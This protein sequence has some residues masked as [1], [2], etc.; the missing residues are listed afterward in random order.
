MQIPTTSISL[1]VFSGLIGILG[2]YLGILKNDCVLF[3]H[4]DR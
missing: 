2:I 3:L 1:D 4:I